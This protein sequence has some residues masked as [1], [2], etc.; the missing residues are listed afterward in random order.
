MW[1]L[2]AFGGADRTSELIK[3]FPETVAQADQLRIG[4]EV[5]PRRSRRARVLIG[6]AVV[7]AIAVYIFALTL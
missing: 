1:N 5:V 4:Y 6:L 3:H 2:G 7:T